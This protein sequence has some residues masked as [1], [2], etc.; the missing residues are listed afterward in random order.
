MQ[1]NPPVITILQI[2]QGVLLSWCTA[3][4]YGSKSPRE[5]WI[6]TSCRFLSRNAL[7]SPNNQLFDINAYK[8]QQERQEARW[9]LGSGAL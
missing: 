9:E 3:E 5:T 8:L 4:Q 7:I 1:N 2:K 6:Y